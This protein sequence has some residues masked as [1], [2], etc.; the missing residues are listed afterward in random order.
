MPPNVEVEEDNIRPPPHYRP[1]GPQQVITADTARQGPSGARVLMML[2]ASMVAIGIAWA[3]LE[4]VF[5]HMH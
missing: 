3:I 1:G 4:I 5:T 2:V